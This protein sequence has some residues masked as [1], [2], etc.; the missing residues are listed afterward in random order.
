MSADGSSAIY[1]TNHWCSAR[2]FYK[3]TAEDVPI[4]HDP[5]L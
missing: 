2:G 5:T 3:I 4:T 1:E